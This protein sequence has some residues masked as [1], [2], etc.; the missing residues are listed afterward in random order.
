MNLLLKA[1]LA[2]TTLVIVATSSPPAT[3]GWD[4]ETLAT[5][6]YCGSAS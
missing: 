1:L 3:V 6:R 4:G 5:V 2:G